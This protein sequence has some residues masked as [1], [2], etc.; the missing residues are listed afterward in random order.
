MMDIS[1]CFQMIF[2]LSDS[3]SMVNLEDLCRRTPGSLWTIIDLM[4]WLAN[5][6]NVWLFNCFL[7]SAVSKGE[8]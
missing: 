4:R 7:Y 1:K 8:L 2:L 5:S 6:N 3:F